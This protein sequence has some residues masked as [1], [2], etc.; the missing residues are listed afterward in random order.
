MYVIHASDGNIPPDM[1]LGE[2]GGLEEE[3]RLLYVALTRAKDRLTVA[4]PQRY[5]HTRFG[6]DAGH[7]YAPLSRFL[8]GAAQRSFEEKSAGFDLPMDG[9]SDGEIGRDRCTTPSKRCGANG[10]G[11]S[12]PGDDNL[13]ECLGHFD[14]GDVTDAAQHLEGP[15]GALACCPSR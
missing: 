6:T 14:H 2:P 3:R 10:L 9:V 13:D 8:T 12:Q 5:Y 7:S 11:G 1:A 4:A 15:V